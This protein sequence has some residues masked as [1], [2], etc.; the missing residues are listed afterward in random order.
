[1]GRIEKQETLHPSDVGIILT[2]PGFTPGI[3]LRIANTAMG[4]K[5]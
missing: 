5:K 1:M 4:R 2:S 3:A